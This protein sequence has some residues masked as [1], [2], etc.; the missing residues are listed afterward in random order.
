MAMGRGES[1]VLACMVV[2]RGECM[3]MR[4]GG[5]RMGTRRGVLRGLGEKLSKKESHLRVDA[6]I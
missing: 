2:G 1:W 4:A 5:G 3:R 6:Q